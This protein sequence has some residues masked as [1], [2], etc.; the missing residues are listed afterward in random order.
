[1]EGKSE[2]TYEY[3]TKPALVVIGMLLCFG[4][5]YAGIHIAT[6]NEKALRL[7]GVTFSP[8][9][10]TILMWGFAAVSFYIGCKLVFAFI[11]SRKGPRLI[12][13]TESGVT[14]PASVT[15]GKYTTVNFSS[16]KDIKLLKNNG[17]LFLHVRHTKGKMVIPS[18]ALKSDGLFQE[19]V[20]KINVARKI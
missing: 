9:V 15:A 1:M 13:L 4:M 17:K 20:E 6:T 19:L 18:V 3:Q 14:A 10:L 8:V 11:Q 16:I 5:S 7:F 2:V 12:T